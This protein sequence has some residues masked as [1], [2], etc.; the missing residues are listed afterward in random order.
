MATNKRQPNFSADEI[1]VMLQLVE[2]SSKL[3]FGKFAS[4]LVTA[5]AKEKCWGEVAQKV[6]AVS[7][8]RR[9]TAEIKK[10]WS[11]IKRLV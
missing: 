1:E 2:K 6:T 8:V 4:G 3:L 9:S 11:Q 7:G 10:K 5:A